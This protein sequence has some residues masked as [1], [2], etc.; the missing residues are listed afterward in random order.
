M[1]PHAVVQAD[2]HGCPLLP[3][4]L[5]WLEDRVDDRHVRCVG[6]HGSMQQRVVGELAVGAHPEALAGFL[7]CCRQPRDLA[8]ITLV[9][10]PGRSSWNQSGSCSRWGLRRS[11]RLQLTW[12]RHLGHLGLMCKPGALVYVERALEVEDRP[13]MLDR[14]HAAWS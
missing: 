14:D 13:P 2:H 6:D 12:S 5:V 7:A 9:D 8:N 3:G 1:E 10:G 4:D 11:R